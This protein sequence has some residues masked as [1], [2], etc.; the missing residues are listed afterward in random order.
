MVNK[1]GSEAIAWP[2]IIWIVIFM[3][4]FVISIVFINK[5]ISGAFIYEEVYAKKIA[6]IVD[7]A[8][9]ESKFY[10]NVSD[11]LESVK[12][13]NYNCASTDAERNNDC[14]FI[15]G[16]NVRVKLFGDDEGY[17]YAFFS[18]YKVDLVLIESQ[19]MLVIGVADA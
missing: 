3:M 6:L 7:G 18:D 13:N 12:K 1:R 19:K 14:F 8:R 9:S 15:E 17:E 4:I 2:Q 11:A 16:N 10:I 5:S